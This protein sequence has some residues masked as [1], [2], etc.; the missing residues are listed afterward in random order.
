MA[1][2]EYEHFARIFAKWDRRF[3]A[4]AEQTLNNGDGVSTCL[5]CGECMDGSMGGICEPCWEVIETPDPGPQ[6]A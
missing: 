3:K 2:I 6:A 5:R 1:F 4:L